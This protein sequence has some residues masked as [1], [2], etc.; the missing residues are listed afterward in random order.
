MEARTRRT[1]IKDENE[2]IEQNRGGLAWVNM[3][4]GNTGHASSSITA[5]STGGKSQFSSTFSSSTTHD[6]TETFQYRSDGKPVNVNDAQKGSVDALNCDKCNNG[7]VWIGINS[8]IIP[9]VSKTALTQKS[10]ASK[11]LA[12][13]DFDE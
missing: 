1:V 2:V 8:G 9:D 10:A 13:D 11:P 3:P 4:E 5:Y 12:A 7:G 6:H